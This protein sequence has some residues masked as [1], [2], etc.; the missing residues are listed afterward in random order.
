MEET[1][2]MLQKAEE[3]IIRLEM[4]YSAA[5]VN[6]LFRIAHTIK[7]SSQMVGY[8]DI[9]NLMHKIE[10][11]LDCT[12]NGSIVFD[13]SIVSLCF[14]GLDTVKKLLQNEKEPD[15]E[16]RM[17]DLDGAAARLNETIEVFI[18]VNKKEEK[19]VTPEPELGIISSLLSI[20]P[21]G[22]RKYYITFFIEED[23]PMVSPVIMIILER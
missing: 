13:Q 1:E 8:V 16:E 23:A 15:S 21:K 6:E 5:D 3:C 17:S 10:D 2:D 4:E 19:A 14:E 22:K 20:T 9:G 12:R 7:G 18:K 11:M